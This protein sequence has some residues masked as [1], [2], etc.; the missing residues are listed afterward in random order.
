MKDKPIFDLLKEH[1]AS[2]DLP[3]HM[4]GHK[5][6]GSLLRG[7]LAFDITEIPGFDDLHDP[8]GIIAYAEESAA[9]V[10][11]AERAHILVNGSTVGILAAFHALCSRGERVIV[12]RNCHKSVYHAIELLDLDARFITPEIHGNDLFYGEILSNNVG[13][14]IADSLAEG[15]KPALAAITSPTYEG[16][17]SDVAAISAVCREYGVP[18]L[19]DSAHGAHLGVIPGFPGSAVKAGADV[20]VLS[21]HKTLASLTQTALILCPASLDTRITHAL[22]IFET[23]SPSY[24]LIGSADECIRRV[25]EN[26]GEISSRWLSAL[27]DC[28]KRLSA[29]RSLELIPVDEPSKLIISTAK[30]GITGGE[31]AITLKNRFSI[32]V[33]AALPGY[34]IAMTGAGDSPESLGRFAD[35]LLAIDG[36]PADGTCYRLRTDKLPPLS[37]PPVSLPVSAALRLPRES[38]PLDKAADRIC[39]EY[40]TPYPPGIPLI[41]PGE[42]VTEEAAEAIRF[43][44]PDR[45]TVLCVV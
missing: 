35:A 31:L 30:C 37:A 20:V 38:V 19:V 21:L 9:R 4:P 2:G 3:M 6:D 14:A 10:W 28:R 32:T 7:L 11:G 23:S 16:V 42:T 36:E 17:I 24:L 1:S 22:D 39:A 33:E 5:R 43:Y 25:E 27:A 26:A 44:L 40:I 18:L 13:K 45:N 34:V 15:K 12:A 29:L 41:V 8:R